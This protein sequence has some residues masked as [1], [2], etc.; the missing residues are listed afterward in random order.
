MRSASVVAIVLLLAAV[1]FNFATA[2]HSAGLNQQVSPL[3]AIVGATLIDGS[4][5]APV[6]DSVVVLKGDSIVSAGKRSQVQVPAGARVIDAAGLVV[7]AGF[8]HAHN[9]YDRGFR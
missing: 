3:I 2:E 6:N 5:H 8:M 7:A 4:G 9:H 1:T